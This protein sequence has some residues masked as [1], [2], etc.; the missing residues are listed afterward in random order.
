MEELCQLTASVYGFDENIPLAGSEVY[1][2]GGM[3][4]GHV[5][6]FYQQQ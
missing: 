2:A 6:P 5:N 1:G 4:E 3:C